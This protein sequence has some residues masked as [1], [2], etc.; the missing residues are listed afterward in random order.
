[1]GIPIDFPWL[2]DEDYE[3]LV[4]ERFGEFDSDDE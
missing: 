2:S 1:M 3:K 4:L